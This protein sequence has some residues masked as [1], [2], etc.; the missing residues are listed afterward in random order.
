[1]HGLLGHRKRSSPGNHPEITAM[2][3]STNKHA[4]EVRDVVG[5]S[6]SSSTA[7]PESA[8]PTQAAVLS[9]RQREL[10]SSPTAATKASITTPT[11]MSTVSN[12]IEQP[13]H[14]PQVLR[15]SKGQNFHPTQTLQGTLSPMLPQN[16]AAAADRPQTAAPSKESPFKKTKTTIAA[17]AEAHTAGPLLYQ[18]REK[19]IIRRDRRGQEIMRSISG[20]GESYSNKCCSVVKVGGSTFSVHMLTLSLC[21]CL[22]NALSYVCLLC[23]WAS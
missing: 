10:H 16:H 14:K 2:T 8:V 19:L 1:M 20:L 5:L 15:R 12:T 6:L 23:N 7:T 3:C 11:S 4:T 17:T 22:P 18:T 9:L 21:N 13:K